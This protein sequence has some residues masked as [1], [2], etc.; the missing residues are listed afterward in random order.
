MM[1][2]LIATGAVA[3]GVLLIPVSEANAQYYSFSYGTQPYYG[4][5][6]AY[7][8]YYYPQYYSQPAY[9]FNFSYSN[10]DWDRGRR[11]DRR[12]R[13]DYRSSRD[14]HRPPSRSPHGPGRPTTW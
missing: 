5:S 7:P 10:R 2:R 3:A 1:K 8:S 6:Y 13:R 14:W 9:S 4:Y 12:D 11:Y